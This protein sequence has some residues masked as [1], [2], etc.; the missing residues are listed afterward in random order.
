M[1]CFRN[2][3]FDEIVRKK[4]WLGINKDTYTRTTNMGNYK[5]KYDVEYVGEK[6]HGN[7]V[8]ASIAIVQLRYLDRDNAY[9]KQLATWYRERFK[10]Y[11]EVIKLVNIPEE[12]SSSNH[13]FQI[14]IDDRDEV[15]MALNAADIFPEFIT[16][17]I[18]YTKCILMHME[19]VLMQNM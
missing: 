14:L 4:G 12:C 13:L 7:S 1:I 19:H 16:L 3:K 2:G 9:R 11:P 5:W 10:D 6:A 17:T 8:I 15:L 18:H